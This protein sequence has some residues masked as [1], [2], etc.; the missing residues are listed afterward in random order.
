M[1]AIIM[2]DT[3]TSR[4]GLQDVAVAEELGLVLG[5]RGITYFLTKIMENSLS[6]TKESMPPHTALNFKMVT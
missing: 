6:V 1:L 4:F 2:I 5:D 3:L